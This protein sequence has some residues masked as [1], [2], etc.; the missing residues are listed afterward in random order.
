MAN[1]QLS[2]CYTLYAAN[3]NHQYHI[4]NLDFLSHG[5][6]NVWLLLF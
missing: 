5:S 1:K 6:T 4:K 3:I 2:H